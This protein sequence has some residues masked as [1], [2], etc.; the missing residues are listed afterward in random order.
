MGMWKEIQQCPERETLGGGGGKL[1]S[2]Y[3]AFK[4][5]R[6]RLILEAIYWILY[7]H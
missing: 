2:S 7:K 1:I 5:W 6:E 4:D 3:T